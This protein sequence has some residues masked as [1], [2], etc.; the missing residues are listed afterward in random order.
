MKIKNICRC[1]IKHERIGVIKMEITHNTTPSLSSL[2]TPPQKIE[3]PSDI[4]L[5]VVKEL[6]A[7]NR[8]NNNQNK[9]EELLNITL[10]LNNIAKKEN[11]DISFEYNEKLQESYISIK[12]NDT[13]KVIRKIPSEEA[14]KF[15]EGVKE[16]LGILFDRRI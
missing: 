1:T 2:V 13:G 15:R 7:N 11:I 4:S 8:S 10:N 14:L 12:D 3:T 16:L 5:A 6:E 9:D